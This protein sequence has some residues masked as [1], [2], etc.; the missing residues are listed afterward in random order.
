MFRRGVAWL[1]RSGEDHAAALTEIGGASGLLST[2]RFG[3]L[4]AVVSALADRYRV[5]GPPTLHYVTVTLL[6][7]SAFFQGE[8]ERAGRLFD[9]SAGIDVPDRTISM[10]AP[11]DARSAFRRGNRSRA[12]R[13]LRAHVDELLRTRYTDIASNAAVEFINMMASIDR[14]KDAARVLSYLATAGDFGALAVRTLVAEAAGKIT[15][16]AGPAPD[17]EQPPGRQLDARQA[18]E[19]MCDVLDELTEVHQPDAP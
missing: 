14:L 18:L 10:N 2:G 15:T 16:G 9:E 8:P 11:V 17:L 6:G 12:F 4:D 5:E 1:R 13:I 3:E 7:Y 19:Y